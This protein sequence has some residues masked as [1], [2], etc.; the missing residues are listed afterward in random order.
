MDKK[1]LNQ[2]SRKVIGAAI[3]VHRNLGPG[4]LESVYEH[5]LCN[6]LSLRSIRFERQKPVE[7]NY[8]GHA[9]GK[10]F[11]IDILIEK[12]L[13]L[14]LKSIEALLPVHETQ[15]L[16]YLKLTHCKLGL[17]LNFNVEQMQKGIKRMVLG[18]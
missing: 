6:E 11:L 9:V 5:C 1:E 15:L 18:F 13:V 16:T 10:T 3:E 8:K 14:E 12:E 17:I 4:L 2:L 7:I